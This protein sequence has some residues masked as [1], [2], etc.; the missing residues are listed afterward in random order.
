MEERGIGEETAVHATIRGIVQGVGFR[1]FVQR[2]A[3]GL[4]IR[5]WVRNL[6]DGSVEVWAEGKRNRLLALLQ[7]LRQGPPHARVDGIDI[8]WREPVGE[9]TFRVRF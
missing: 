7:A 6:P 1:F 9:M 8:A 5:G 3:R 2:Q 4:G